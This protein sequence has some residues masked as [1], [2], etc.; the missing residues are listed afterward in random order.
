MNVNADFSRRALVHGAAI[1]WEPSPMP[2]VERRRLDRVTG[3]HER[4]T[5]IVRYAPGSR[6]SPHV[7]G[8]G[9]EFLVLDGVFE[10]GYGAWPTGSYI[11]NPPGSSH[12]P[13][14][15][16]GCT[17]L[18]K[19]WQFD[20]DDRTFVH[21]HIDK[22]TGVPHRDRPGVRVTPLYTDAAESVSVERWAPDASVTL[23]TRG[24]TEL[25]V[26]EGQ[27]RQADEALH[28]WSWL[29]LPPGA[30]QVLRAGP[31]GTRVWTKTG[32]LSA[33]ARPA[34]KP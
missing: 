2:G 30:P 1:D 23:D 22:L 12:T 32:H 31:N 28:R 8:G 20:P 21:A 9:E 26:L 15:A 19:L 34:G 4:V 14:S 18:V 13:G 17:I 3:E 5:T 24:G 33:L 16:P 29:R 6:F 10:D 11:R 25:F 7:H 27:A